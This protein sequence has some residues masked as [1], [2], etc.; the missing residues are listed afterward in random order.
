MIESVKCCERFLSLPEELISEMDEMLALWLAGE[1]E[2]REESTNFPRQN[3]E[4][5]AV[6]KV[7]IVTMNEARPSRVKRWSIS[8]RNFENSVL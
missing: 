3:E 5:G 7:F 4:V 6:P 8:S 2:D 1:D